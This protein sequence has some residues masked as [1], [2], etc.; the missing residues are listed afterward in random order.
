MALLPKDPR[1]QRYVLYILV[2]VVAAAAYYMLVF[3]KTGEGLTQKADRVAALSSMNQ[4]ANQELARGDLARLRAE[5]T[6]YQQNLS[7]IRTLVPQS[8]E[9]PSLLEQIS[10]AARRVGLDLSTVDPQPVTPGDNYDTY[11]YNV[12]VVGGYH[13]L[14]EF[15]TNVGSLTRIVLPVNLTLAPSST[16]SAKVKAKRGEA[17]VEAKLQ[18][19]T[20]VAHSS[21]PD[22][23]PPAKKGA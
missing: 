8:N 10:T 21:R 12:S 2:G 11:R 23:L 13:E 20:F 17:M 3:Q 18:L 7:L 15:L 9:V 5:L 14:A 4:K 6:M 16:N 22:D 19:M 1:T